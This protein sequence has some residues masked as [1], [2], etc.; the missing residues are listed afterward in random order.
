[1]ASMFLCLFILSKDI[2]HM[3]VYKCRDMLN[4]D[5][6]NLFRSFIIPT[7]A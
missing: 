6:C 4:T 3:L 2:L 7:V 5:T 1:M